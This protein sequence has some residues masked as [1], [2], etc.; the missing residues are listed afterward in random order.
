MESGANK[1]RMMA[2]VSVEKAL[3]R[4]VKWRMIFAG[5]QLGTRSKEDPEAQAVRDTR[6]LLMLL[7]TEVNALT[8]CLL[9]SKALTQDRLQAQL[10]IEAKMLEEAFEA[11]WPGAKA[12]DDGITLDQRAQAWMSKWRP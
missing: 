3:N 8:A 9:E 10:I 7:R 4:L 11:R 1:S 6:E 2:A 12:T 5:W